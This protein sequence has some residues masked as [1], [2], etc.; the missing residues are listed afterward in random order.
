MEVGAVAAYRLQSLAVMALAELGIFY[1][2]QTVLQTNSGADTA[3]AV[4][5]VA[6]LHASILELIADACVFP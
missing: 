2:G 3:Q 6:V 4:L 5:T 1:N